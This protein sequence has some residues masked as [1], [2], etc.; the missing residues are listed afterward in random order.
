[1]RRG[2]LKLHRSGGT[3]LR[4]GFNFRLHVFLLPAIQA[5]SGQNRFQFF[6]DLRQISGGGHQNSTNRKNMPTNQQ[7]WGAAA[8]EFGEDEK[9]NLYWG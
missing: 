5:K 2:A 4:C 3:W 1:M 6:L 8:G 9:D 7:S